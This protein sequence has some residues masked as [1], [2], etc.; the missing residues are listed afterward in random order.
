MTKYKTMDKIK[1]IIIY[2][3]P[4][5]FLFFSLQLVEYVFNPTDENHLFF[6]VFKWGIVAICFIANS[7]KYL[8]LSHDENKR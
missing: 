1:Y 3:S 4:V 6:L 7:I 5:V 8:R 2:F